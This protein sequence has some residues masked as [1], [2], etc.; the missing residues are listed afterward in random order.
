VDFI[1]INSLLIKKLVFHEKDQLRYV[2][3]FSES[4]HLSISFAQP[5]HN[6][7]SSSLLLIKVLML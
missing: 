6:L 2:F 3:D 1:R 7:Y 5:S 4:M